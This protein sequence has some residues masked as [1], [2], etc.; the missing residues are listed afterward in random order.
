[1]YIMSIT[2]TLPIICIY[3]QDSHI[4]SRV[5]IMAFGKILKYLREYQHL[6]Q[7]RMAA[8]LGISQS[9]Y[10]RYELGESSPNIEMLKKLS[11]FFNVPID[12][13]L[14]NYNYDAQDLTDFNHFILHGNYTLFSR[15]PT[16]DD[17]EM[18]STIVTAIF[19]RDKKASN[20]Q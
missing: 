7:K 16:A 1:M 15:F 14:E 9:S 18:L 11:N 19:D 6:D 10:S 17:R 4:I 3:V 8:E 13:L 5:I 2:T 20:N 12:Y